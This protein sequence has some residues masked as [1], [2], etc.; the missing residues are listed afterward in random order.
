M[1]KM[2]PG[3]RTQRV[4]MRRSGS[5]LRVGSGTAVMINVRWFSVLIRCK[6]FRQDCTDARNDTP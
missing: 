3:A 5:G 1:R 6:Y 2:V 4:R